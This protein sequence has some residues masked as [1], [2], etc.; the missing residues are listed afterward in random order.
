MNKQSNELGLISLKTLFAIF[1]LF[2]AVSFT[3]SAF[4]DLFGVLKNLGYIEWKNITNTGYTDLRKLFLDSGLPEFSAAIVFTIVSLWTLIN[5]ILFWIAL[6]GLNQPSQIWLKK[7]KVAY[8]VSLSYWVL[9]LWGF[10]MLLGFGYGGQ[11][12]VYV[13]HMAQWL[14]ELLTFGFILMF[15]N[16]GRIR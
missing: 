13:N 1:L 16:E 9:F 14:F 5:G 7:V 4:S 15:N 12:T 6:F 11:T 8:I 10:Q 3:F 2:W